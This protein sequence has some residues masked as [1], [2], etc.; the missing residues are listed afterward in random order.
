MKER[1]RAFTVLVTRISRAIRKIKTEEMHEYGLSN[2]HVSC[3]YYLYKE[4][5]LSAKELMDIC[6][7][8]KAS[9]SRA[10]AYLEANAYIKCDSNQK[11]RYNNSFTL[12]DRGRETARG[13]AEKVDKILDYASSGLSEEKRNNMY[14]GLMLISDNLDK[15]C[16]KYEGEE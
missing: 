6:L 7:E 3:L 8:D 1:F 4:S 16:N 13:I 14:D 10:L 2:T 11:K 9:L 12:T 5:S 15:F